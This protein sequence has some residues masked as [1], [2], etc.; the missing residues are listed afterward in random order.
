MRHTWYGGK[1]YIERGAMMMIVG[2][3]NTVLSQPEWRMAAEDYAGVHV[4]LKRACQG[5]FD[6]ISYS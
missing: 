3:Q 5:N 4:Q 1:P 2:K 6:C